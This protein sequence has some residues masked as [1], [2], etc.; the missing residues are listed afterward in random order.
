MAYEVWTDPGFQRELDKL[1]KPQ[2]ALILEGIRGLAHHPIEHP[3]VVRLKGTKYPGSFRLRVGRYRVVGIILESPKLILLTTLFLKK[4]ES[5]YDQAADRH[6]HRLG[7]QGP[8][9]DE[10][11]RG[12]RRRR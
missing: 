8:P 1:P 9:L 10:Y 7:A 12:A 4:R 11:V 6:E 2:R 5:D 3:Q